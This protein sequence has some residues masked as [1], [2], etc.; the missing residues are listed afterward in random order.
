MPRKR[1]IL[2]PNQSGNFSVAGAGWQV[3]MG[4]SVHSV[5]KVDTGS[6]MAPVFSTTMS[7]HTVRERRIYEKETEM[8]M[9]R[10]VAR[11]VRPH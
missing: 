7:A 6:A 1:G 9:H 8:F 4:A 5:T 10:C 3:V 11:L 2:V